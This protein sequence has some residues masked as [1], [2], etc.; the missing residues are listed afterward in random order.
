ME[1]FLAHFLDGTQAPRKREAHYKNTKSAG[2]GQ[3]M[4]TKGGKWDL[5]GKA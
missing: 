4:K 3:E 2:V 5:K 1:A